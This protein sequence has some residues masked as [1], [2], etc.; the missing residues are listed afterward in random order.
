MNSMAKNSSILKVC[1]FLCMTGG[2]LH[3]QTIIKVTDEVPCS[4]APTVYIGNII[5]RVTVLTTHENKVK[6]VTSVAYEGNCRYTND[7]WLD[8]L[9]LKVRGDGEDIHVKN[10]NMP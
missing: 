4:A 7:Q 9:E 6:L 10:G 8:I 2:G 5:R 1:L 3:A